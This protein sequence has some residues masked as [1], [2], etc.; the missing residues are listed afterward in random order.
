MTGSQIEFKSWEMSYVAF[1]GGNGAD[2][3]GELGL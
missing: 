2:G 3:Q 1:D